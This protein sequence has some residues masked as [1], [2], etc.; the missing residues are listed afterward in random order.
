M[1]GT[2]LRLRVVP[3]AAKPGVVG[4]HGDAWKLRVREAPDRGRANDAVLDLLAGTL[5]VPRRDLRLVSGHGARDKVVE[6]A[7]ITTEEINRRLAAAEQE[8]TR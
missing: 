6:L 4:R 2:R 5:V 3:G 7:G 1:G 8:G